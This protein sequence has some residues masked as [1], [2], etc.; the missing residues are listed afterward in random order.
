L[1]LRICV[2]VVTNWNTAALNAI[3]VER[4][5]P[6]RLR[7]TGGPEIRGLDKQECRALVI[8]FR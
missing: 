2:C 4:T 3:R 8:P 6:P 7:D 5:T 1:Y